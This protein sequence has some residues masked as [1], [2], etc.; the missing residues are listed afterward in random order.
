MDSDFEAVVNQYY[1]RCFQEKEDYYQL[2]GVAQTATQKQLTEAYSQKIDTF[3]R[4]KI[5]SLPA[6]EIKEKAFYALDRIQHMYKLL[7][8]FKKR[9]KYEKMGNREIDPEDL[10]EEDPVEKAKE[11][12]RVGKSMYSQKQW[13]MA[14]TAFNYA[15]EL[16][17]TKA[18]YYLHV[19]L[20]QMKSPHLRRDAEKSI[21][22]AIEME[23]WNGEHYAA[24]GA[25]YMQEKLNNRAEAQFRKALELDPTNKSAKKGLAA[26]APPEDKSIGALI[27]KYK[28][29]VM[30]ILR[31]CLPSIFKRKK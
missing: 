31:L 17:P 12:F 23:D 5:E 7:A 26:V 11:N 30:K 22:Q 28:P 9:A 25:L 2:L 13:Q 1:E 8:D 19:G 29:P 10:K 14:L 3:S 4:E 20:C 6:G 15:I 27:Q 24:L 21:K 18:A 16:D